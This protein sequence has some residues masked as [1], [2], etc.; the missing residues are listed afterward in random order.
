M[1][2]IVVNITYDM[3]KN[4]PLCTP[5]RRGGGVVGIRAFSSHAEGRLLESQ[6][7]QPL[8]VKTGS[9]SSTAK[10]WAT[11]ESVTGPQGNPL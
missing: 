5:K 4:S 6:P 7:Q 10:R 8:F 3:Y 11:G 1:Y 2:L 9:D